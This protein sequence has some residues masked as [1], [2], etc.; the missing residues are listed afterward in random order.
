[1]PF[2]INKAI[3]AQRVLDLP[4][5]K[6]MTNLLSCLKQGRLLRSVTLSGSY[7][8]RVVQEFICNL[9][10]N[11]IVPES[12][13][14]HKVFV[15]GKLYDISP[16]AIRNVLKCQVTESDAPIQEDAMW[17]ELTNGLRSSQTP[18]TRVQSALLKSSYAVLLRIAASN[19]MPTTHKATVPTSLAELIYKIKQ[20]LSVDLGQRIYDLLLSFSRDTNKINALGIPFPVLIYQLLLSLGFQKKD[21][22]MEEPRSV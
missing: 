2:I 13:T 16:S 19:W 14:F 18:A 6:S 22:E 10:P 17:R 15:R 8:R 4:S 12:H 21:V 9:H 11:V 7:V 5:F 3:I 1:M 20:G